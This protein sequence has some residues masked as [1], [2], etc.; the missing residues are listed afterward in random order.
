MSTEKATGIFPQARLDEMVKAARE[1]DFRAFPKSDGDDL[2]NDAATTAYVAR[3]LEY[4]RPAMFEIQYPA[5]KGK[6]WVPINSSMPVGAEQ[7]TITIMDGVGE[8]KHVKDFAKDVSRVE[9]S[10]RQ[11]SMNV[12]S[13]AISYAWN[14]NELRTAMYGN[15]PLPTKKA[16]L[17]RDLMARKFDDILLTGD[18]LTGIKGLFN[19]TGTETYTVTADGT[20]GSATFETKNADKICRDLN[21][22]LGQVVV[23]SKE[24]HNPN[25]VIMPL[26]TMQYLG[27]TRVGDGTSETILAYWLRTNPYE[28]RTAE[29]SLKLETAGSG[30]TKRIVAY[31]KSPQV[32][33]AITPVEFEQFA[34]ET[35]NQETQ[36][37]CQMRVGGVAL[38]MPKAVIYADGV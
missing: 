1:F 9:V 23:N 27:G 28:I 14:I 10:T 8:V 13:M 3:Q 29:Q 34:P 37:I 36:T 22:A 38:Y 24:V 20:G 7:Y 19:L 17:A 35:F 21:G 25:T 6:R 33:E 5:L 31:E 18:T 12:F 11:A 16:M 4:L 26:S 2:R 15:L 30:N 32:L